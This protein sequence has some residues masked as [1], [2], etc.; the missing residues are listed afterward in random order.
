MPFEFE[1][2]KIP[3]VILIKP[4]EFMDGRGSYMETY[5]E[6]DFKK[7]GIVYEFK[8]DNHSKSSKGVLRGLHYQLEPFEQG[9]IVRAVRGKV[10]DVAVDIR[11][12]SPYYGKYVCAELSSENRLMLWVPPGFAHGFISLQEDSEVI[13]KTTKEYSPEHEAG[14]LWNDP[15]LGIDWRTKEPIISKKD[16][17]LPLLKDA[18]NNFQYKE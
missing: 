18:K 1:R 14:I 2:L 8:Q 5:K 16:S 10:L 12:G 13:Y 15:E 7:S 17:V 9:K 3:D 11:K 4:K 6:S